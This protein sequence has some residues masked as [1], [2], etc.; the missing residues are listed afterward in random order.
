MDAEERKAAVLEKMVRRRQWGMN[1]R[2]VEKTL[3]SVPKRCRR[4]ARKDLEEL[5][6]EGWVERHKNGACVSL[7]PTARTEIRRFLERHGSIERWL[8]DRLF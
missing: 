1:Y 7:D 6:R 4:D 2:P 8:L 5:A 3:S